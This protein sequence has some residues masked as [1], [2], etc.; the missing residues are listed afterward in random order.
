[1][2]LGRDESSGL[3]RDDDTGTLEDE[4]GSGA[5]RGSLVGELYGDG[6]Y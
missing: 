3:R 4:W 6:V 2:L 5:I 1:M